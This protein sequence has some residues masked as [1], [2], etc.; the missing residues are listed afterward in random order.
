MDSRNTLSSKRRSVLGM[1]AAAT[2]L[3]AVS[4][5]G[6]KPAIAQTV[7]NWPQRPVKWIVSQPGGAGPD[8]LARV[9][10]EGLSKNW[11]QTVVI[12]NRPGGQNVIGAQAAARSAADGYTFFYATTAAMITN[13]FTFK[14]LPY[15]PDKDFSPVAFIGRSPFMIA[16]SPNANFKSLADA[17]ALAKAQPE[18]I[19]M[20]TEGPKTFSGILAASVASMAEVSFNQVAYTKA[21]DA[22]QDVIGGR[23]ALI[24]LP[25]A[26]LMSFVR[27]GQLQ[28]LAISTAQRLPTLPGLPALS[29]TFKGFEYTGWNGLFAPAG[30]PPDVIAKVNKDV[31]AFLRQPDS[32]QRLLSLGSLA[33]A[34]M[35]PGEFSNFLNSERE[36]WVGI[37][38]AIG[39]KPE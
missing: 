2:S 14:T 15:D 18:K 16:A 39:L 32:I 10:A 27:S 33:D 30:T 35:S 13:R 19:G 22:I 21:T 9:I 12:E 24:C 25:E 29:E 37:V 23:V 36:R 20:A 11:G 17:L 34:G 4:A 5:L 38:K 31:V 8:I 28:A 3:V 26:A 1:A 7:G 6:L